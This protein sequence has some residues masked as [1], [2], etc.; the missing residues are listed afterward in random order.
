MSGCGG[1][2]ASDRANRQRAFHTTPDKWKDVRVFHRPFDEQW[3]ERVKVRKVATQDTHSEKVYSPNKA[4]WYSV[5]VG[6]Q[7]AG[8]HTGQVHDVNID[9]FNERDYLVRLELPL[10][11]M[12][13]ERRMQW[14]NEKLLYVR[15]WWGR[16]LGVDMVFDVETEQ[17]VYMENVNFGTIPFLQWQQAKME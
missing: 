3:S 17:I 7:V 16:A 4:Y 1:N 2:A 5:T 12:N 15:V 14:I 10:T 11:Y 9:I 13:F 8:P 6:P